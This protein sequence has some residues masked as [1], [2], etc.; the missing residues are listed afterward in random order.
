LAYGWK[1]TVGRS[2]NGSAE[3]LLVVIA[4]ADGDSLKFVGM[5]KQMQKFHVSLVDVVFV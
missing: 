2:R 3:A 4:A 5:M 1:R